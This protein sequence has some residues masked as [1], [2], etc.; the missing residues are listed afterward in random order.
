[1]RKYN[2]Q[3]RLRKVDLFD[4]IRSDKGSSNVRVQQTMRDV[5]SIVNNES[6]QVRRI[7][8][9]NHKGRMKPRRLKPLGKYLNHKRPARRYVGKHSHF[10]NRGGALGMTDNEYRDYIRTGKLPERMTKKFE[11]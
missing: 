1:M 5:N 10:T 4:L 8:T 9:T 3:D 7:I 6:R 11:V 2:Q